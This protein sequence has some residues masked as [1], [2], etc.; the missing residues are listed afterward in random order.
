MGQVQVSVKELLA[1]RPKHRFF[2]SV[3]EPAGALAKQRCGSIATV[4]RHTQWL[5]DADLSN[6]IGWDWCVGIQLF[7][8]L[9]EPPAQAAN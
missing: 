5:C 8:L 7:S 4:S 2:A 9:C 1:L 6:S 3:L